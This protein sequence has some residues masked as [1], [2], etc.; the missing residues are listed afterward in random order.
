MIVLH[1]TRG[2][3][4]LGLARTLHDHSIRKDYPFTKVDAV[5]EPEAA[6]AELCTQAGCG[7]I[8]LDLTRPFS[9]PL[10]FARNLLSSH[11]HLWTIA[12]APT[13][14]DIFKHFG[15]AFSEPTRAGFDLCTL[16][17]PRRGWHLNMGPPSFS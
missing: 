7:T 3:E 12:V 16:G 5:P 10:Q 15:G 9:I 2:D 11:F 14:D 13:P 4:A 17:F 1:G 6:I 8:F